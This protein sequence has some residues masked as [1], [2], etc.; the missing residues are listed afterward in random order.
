MS[1]SAI[2]NRRKA[3]QSAASSSRIA[4]ATYSDSECATE[5]PSASG[6]TSAAHTVA[7]VIALT[8]GVQTRTSIA[9]GCCD[10]ARVDVD[11]IGDATLTERPSSV[12]RIFLAAVQNSTRCLTSCAKTMEGTSEADEG[13]Q[14]VRGQGIPKPKRWM[15]VYRECEVSTG[16]GRVPTVLEVRDDPV[17]CAIALPV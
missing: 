6:I 16:C 8:S 14:S 10:I 2:R 15:Y 11:G 1:H 12:R 4:A 9:V 17:L 5:A 7:A 3:T 13:C